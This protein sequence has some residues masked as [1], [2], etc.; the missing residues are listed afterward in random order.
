M[1]LSNVTNYFTKMTAITIIEI[2]CSFVMF[3]TLPSQMNQVSF[4]FTLKEIIFIDQ[5]KKQ[6]RMDSP[7]EGILNVMFFRLFLFKWHEL[8]F[9]LKKPEK[10]KENYILGDENPTME[11]Q[12]NEYRRKNSLAG[13]EQE[14]NTKHQNRFEVP[15]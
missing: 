11:L 5:K 9:S 7:D 3:K 15:V 10:L 1:L 6:H 13:A 4:L 14:K 12:R 2:A 8:K